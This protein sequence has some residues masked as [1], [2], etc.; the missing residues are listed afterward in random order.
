[1][2]KQT[3][4]PKIL[5]HATAAL[6]AIAAASPATAAGTLVAFGD[7]DNDGLVDMAVVT[8]STTITVNLTNPDGSYTVSAILTVPKTQKITYIDA[9]DRDG[10]GDLDVSAVCPAGAT[11]SYTHT[12]LGNGDGTF[13]SRTTVKWW[14]RFADGF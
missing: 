1:M 4:I 5:L 11:W 13:G 6:I 2:K 9:Y 14:R 8:S 12:W 10:D 7:F 3:I